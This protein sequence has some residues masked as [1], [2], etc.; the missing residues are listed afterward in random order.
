MSGKAIR[1]LAALRDRPE[2]E[3]GKPESEWVRATTIPVPRIIRNRLERE[4]LIEVR[5]RKGPSRLPVIDV[6]ITQA[7]LVKLVDVAASGSR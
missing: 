2:D 3:N 7:G 5:Y 1:V 6:R 4:G